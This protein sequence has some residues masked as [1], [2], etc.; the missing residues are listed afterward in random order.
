[1]NIGQHSISAANIA[2]WL[3]MTERNARR[4]LGDL[5]EYGLAE[6]I[7]EEAPAS[8]GRPRKIY[9]ITPQKVT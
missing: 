1:K 4:I 8:R 7:G 2:E 6:I 3:G 5:A 9:R